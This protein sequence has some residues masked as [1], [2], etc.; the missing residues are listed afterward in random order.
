MPA[1]NVENYISK[2]IESVIGQTYSCFELIVVI[3][4]SPD[5]SGIIAEEFAAEDSRITV[6]YKEN[7]GLSDA[8]NFGMMHAKGKYLYFLDSDDFIYSDML[9]NVVANAEEHNADIVIFGY[10]AEYLNSSGYLISE[11]T[12][13][14]PFGVYD[15]YN[16]NSIEASK[17]FLGLI[18]YAWNKLYRH[19][20]IK[21]NNFSF[22]KGL[23]LVEDI[24]FNAPVLSESNKIVI[25]DHC[26]YRYMQ[27]PRVTLGNDYYKN[28]F[29]LKTLACES[30][31]SL[32][33]NW[34]YNPEYV[35][36]IISNLYFSALKSS[37]KT[38]CI[39][40]KLGYEKKYKEVVEIIN[41][42]THQQTLE[43]VDT[44]NLK[45][46]MILF[47]SR[48]QLPSMLLLLYGVLGKKK[49]Y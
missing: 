38:I 11:T 45:D 32:L 5:N 3:D 1:Y 23:S 8:R 18:G 46:K 20:Y 48:Y 16:F 43:N 49:M 29:D 13:S 36:K 17:E 2:S 33:L 35:D 28:Q 12:V 27:R 30:R 6:L 4:G 44:T 24:V 25:L 47:L 26:Y 41:T 9:E 34:G 7:G 10:K 15:K 31:R 22:K 37:L 42:V 39:S 21:E 19:S 40:K 14:V